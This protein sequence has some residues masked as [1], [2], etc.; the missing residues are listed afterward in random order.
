MDLKNKVCK[1]AKLGVFNSE[2]N[3]L[4]GNSSLQFKK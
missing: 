1:M 3:W 2:K 4:I